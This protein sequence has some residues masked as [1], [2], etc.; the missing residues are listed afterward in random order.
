MR[1]PLRFSTRV[2]VSEVALATLIAICSAPALADPSCHNLT[3]TGLAF[4][5]YDPLSATPVFSLGTVTFN[6]PPPAMAQVSLSAGGSGTFFPRGMSNPA[7]PVRLE[8]NLYVDATYT[9]VWGDGTA[10]T[11]AVP[12]TAKTK[13]MDVYGRIPPYQDVAVGTFS[14]TVIVTFNF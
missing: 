1:W 13:S 14:D 5:P 2:S 9:T 10:G 11:A 6:C 3:A 4:G 7:D 12:V 8:Y